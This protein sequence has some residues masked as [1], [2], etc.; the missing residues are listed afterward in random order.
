MYFPFHTV[1]LNFQTAGEGMDLNDGLFRQ[2]NSCGYVLKPRFMREAEKFD[3]ETPHER[4]GYQPVVLTIQ[5]HNIGKEIKV[6][7][8]SFSIIALYKS[9]YGCV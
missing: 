3:P 8:C 7:P 2:N 4:E 6:F 1:A 9:L 5:V